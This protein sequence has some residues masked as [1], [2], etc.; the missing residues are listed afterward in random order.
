MNQNEIIERH[1]QGFIEW[2]ADA[3]LGKV[4]KSTVTNYIRALSNA[5]ED[6]QIKLDKNLL[7]VENVNEF[8]EKW[9]IIKEQENYQYINDIRHRVFSSGASKY[10][11]YLEYLKKMKP[12]TSGGNVEHGKSEGSGVIS[13][14]KISITFSSSYPRNWIFFGAPGTGKS[15]SLEQKRKALVGENEASYERVTFHPAYTYANFV[16]A[17]KPTM[18]KVTDAN[19]EVKEEIAY[20]F[21][22]GPFTRVLV[23]A[24]NNPG[25]P[26]LL[27]IEEIN[28]AN[29]A[30]VFGDVFQL[31]DRNEKHVSEYPV[32]TSE[33]LRDYL[34]GR[35]VK[36]YEKLHLPDNMF[37]WASMNSA[38]QGVFPM[39]TA[40]KRRWEF[41]YISIDEGE[42]KISFR[43]FEV[44]NT[45]LNW[46]KLRKAINTALRKQH[47]NEDKLMGPF[48]IAKRTV[49]TATDKEF[50]K[51]F[52]N[53]VIMYLFE[54]AAR[55]RREAI[56]APISDALCYSEICKKFS[57]EGIKAFSSEVQ[58]L[59]GNVE[60]VA[61]M[62][63]TDHEQ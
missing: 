8:K 38:D 61:T 39:D 3:E 16:G 44:A 11:D 31:L 2:C 34:A 30:A 13:Q 59:Y 32:H 25:K 50:I 55:T 6:F 53:K 33:D 57:D 4:G 45:K 36:D 5:E 19:G 48:F 23:N 20:K 63:N 10:I 47:I 9:N 7:A 56:F 27:L 28:R 35:G 43:D 58:K 40:F 41:E 60:M 12:P 51:A 62:E 26:Y 14:P 15:F 18:K 52:N 17:Y 22:P 49:D 42:D 1:K 37:I 54:D 21:V 29:V 24:L 46:N